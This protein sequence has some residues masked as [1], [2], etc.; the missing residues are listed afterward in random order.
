M[1]VVHLIT[2][3]R[4]YEIKARSGESLLEC[5]RRSNIP[6]QACLIL[7]PDKSFISLS[8]TLGEGDE[9]WAYSLRNP[10]FEILQPGLALMSVSDAVTELIRPVG[11]PQ[12]LALMQFS[13]PQA[14]DYVYASFRAAMDS[15]IE[16]REDDLPIQVA[17][18]SGGD[19]RVL[20][21]CVRRYIDEDS[22][23]VFHCVIMAAGFEDET[24]HLATAAKIATMF[25]LPYETYDAKRVSQKLGMK[26]DVN[27]VMDNFRSE[28][29]SDELEVLGT[30]WIQQ[31]NFLV[32][33]EG[34]RKGIIFGYNQEDVIADRLYHTM[35]GTLLPT[36]PVRKAGQFDIIAP[37]FQTPKRLLDSLD[38]ENSIRNYNRRRPSVSYLRSSLYFLAYLIC[39]R[40]PALADVFSG[41]SLQPRDPD[42]IL[43]W[44]ASQ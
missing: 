41:A 33:G 18:S 30:Y 20:A 19:A 13:R 29:P 25:N 36:Y 37:L 43:R 5:M 14:M 40:F 44:M 8:H 38:I 26:Q 3:E 7:G 34:G 32:A 16:T 21:E 24:E 1:G 31:L 39:E 42:Q 10:D 22:D 11:S 35:V 17:L 9:V 28:F 27:T 2:T 6:V 23:V 12:R 15:Y 4:S